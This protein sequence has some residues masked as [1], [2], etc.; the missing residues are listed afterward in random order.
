[1]NFHRLIRQLG[2]SSRYHLAAGVASLVVFSAPISAGRDVPEVG[3]GSAWPVMKPGD[4]RRDV[5]ADALYFGQLAFVQSDI[6]Q[7]SQGFDHDGHPVLDIALQPEATKRLEA[8]TVRL[9]NTD[10]TF[11]L[12]SVT[13]I[14]ALL[15][16]PITEGKLRISGRFSLAETQAMARQIICALGLSAPQY[17]PSSLAARLPCGPDKTQ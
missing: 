2:R 11:S 8:E 12:G 3:T 13:L 14:S 10:V 9:L 5:R 15:V 1:M 16:E 7:L 17:D 4:D 6:A